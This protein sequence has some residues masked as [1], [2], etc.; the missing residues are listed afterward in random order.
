MYRLNTFI[1]GDSSDKLHNLIS[2]ILH[3]GLILLFLANKF[4]YQ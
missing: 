4:H 1:K 3:Y 2:M